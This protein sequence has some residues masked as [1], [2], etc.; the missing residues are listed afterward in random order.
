[1]DVQLNV[2]GWHRKIQEWSF[3]PD[4]P[5]MESLCPYFWLTVASV[6]VS[7]VALCLRVVIAVA[8]TILL[9]AYSFGNIVKSY[10]AGLMIAGFTEKAFLPVM[11]LLLL[12]GMAVSTYQTHGV[13]LAVLGSVLLFSVL[14][15]VFA[16]LA[17]RGLRLIANAWHMT[18][19]TSLLTNYFVAVKNKVCP[20][21]EWL[22]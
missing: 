13:F 9:K 10:R 4:T 5:R 20:T 22:G 18:P 2:D 21:I 11:G 6:L 14:F 17:Y 16:F 3:G 1:M 7:P 19:G 15:V 12:V 8:N